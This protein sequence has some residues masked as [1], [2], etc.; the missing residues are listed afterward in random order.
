MHILR[1][2]Q[3]FKKRITIQLVINSSNGKNRVWD[4]IF[5]RNKVKYDQQY[6]FESTNFLWSKQRT[7]MYSGKKNNL[8][9]RF[10]ELRFSKLLFLFLYFYFIFLSGFWASFLVILGVTEGYA[11]RNCSFISSNSCPKLISKTHDS[12]FCENIFF[13][14]VFLKNLDPDESG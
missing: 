4:N 7:D 12:S 14:V 5:R 13:L 1:K 10:S 3:N 9:E 8:V 2:H 11:P 6:L